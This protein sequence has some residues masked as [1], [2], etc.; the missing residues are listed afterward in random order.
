MVF[1]DI[2]EI[3]APSRGFEAGVRG[4][5]VSVD[6]LTERVTLAI[7]CDGPTPLLVPFER[8]L[9]QRLPG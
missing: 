1:G 9:V 8:Q 7:E 2:A 4:T 6:D 5:I 3:K